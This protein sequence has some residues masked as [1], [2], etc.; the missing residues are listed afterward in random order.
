MY[1]CH[2]IDIANIYNHV[3]KCVA[4]KNDKTEYT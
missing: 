3:A 4:N 2:V 1:N